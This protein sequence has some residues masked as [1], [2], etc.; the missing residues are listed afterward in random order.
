MSVPPR[1]T[2]PVATD[3]ELVSVIIPTFNRS[4]ML[5]QT[6]D[7]VR[8]Q[9]LPAHEV[10]VV[11]DGSTDETPELM[12][13]LMR[14]WN[15]LRYLR[16]PSNRGA[17]RARQAGF[18]ESHG[19]YIVFLD[20]DDVWLPA[21]L[22][23]CVGAFRAR[24]KAAM[25]F[26][27]YGVMGP[28]GQVFVPRVREP[29][30]SNPPLRSLLL[31][32]VIVQYSRAVYGR[33]AVLEAGGVPASVTADDWVLNVSIASRH[34]AGIVSLRE[35]TVF[36]RL[37]AGNSAGNPA[38]TR[39]CL[40]QS[41]EQI[42]DALPD[43]W[44]RIKPRVRAINFLHS[45]VFFWHAGATAEARRCLAQA[46][47]T[48]LSCMVERSFRAALM[49]LLV[50]GSAGRVLRRA[51]RQVQRRLHAASVDGATPT[52][53]ALK[54][55]YLCYFGLREP[56][57]QTQVLPYLRVL[58][59]GGITVT[60]LTFEPPAR[61]GWPRAD[62]E[63]WRR[64][65]D[66][67]GIRWITRPYHK[68]PSALVTLYDIL[69]GAWTA[70]RLLRRERMAVLHARSHVPMAMALLAQR[71]ARCQLVFDVR[72]LLAEEYAAAGTWSERSLIFRAV[73]W[74]ERVGLR[75]ADRIV[76]LTHRFREW[77]IEQRLVDPGRIEVI[78]CCVDLARF[79]NGLPGSSAEPDRFEVVYVGSVTGLYL[80]EE[81]GRFFLAL[82]TLRP[83]A[84]LR[85]LTQEPPTH[86]ARIFERLGVPPDAWW[87]G[88]V[89]PDEIPGSLRRAR[90]GLSF[91][92]PTFAQIAACPTKIAEYLA[93]GLP[94]VSSGGVGDLDELLIGSRVGVVVRRLEPDAYPEAAARAL[95]LADDPEVSARCVAVA[96]E[97]FDL[98]RVGGARYRALYHSLKQER[99]WV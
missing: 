37:H 32:Q 22:E 88:T 2:T 35:C 40:L 28:D 51:K 31:K 38:K 76:V 9:T 60:L 93:M 30:L 73:K 79:R 39:D 82:R 90:L 14:G 61:R 68:R 54:T 50:S 55:L 94:V 64:R 58:C 42:F 24:P 75:R 46:V 57:V 16:F 66:A 15:N 1:A 45:A 70:A 95:A 26:T 59:A 17:D 34:P 67:E 44:Q 85:I 74:M 25:V 7:S 49:R 96:R 91:R 97:Q 48:D 53:R 99:A 78:P 56:L 6:L 89:P 86:A 80:G 77:L 84:L 18:E 20:S 83:N 11:D 12:A 3:R 33:W 71:L 62:R 65:L 43:E 4:S 23:R 98:E 87:I 41:T 29:R 5:Q 52:R 10:V 63:E 27:R 8:R 69:V 81:M 13:R 47:Q 21:H 36:N 19:D 92:R 72:G